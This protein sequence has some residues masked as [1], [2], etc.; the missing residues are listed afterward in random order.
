M[1]KFVFLASL[2]VMS[3][4]ILGMN[5]DRV[6]DRRYSSPDIWKSLRTPTQGRRYSAPDG[7][8]VLENDSVKDSDS[9][10]NGDAKIIK[11]HANGDT[12]LHLAVKK[13]QSRLGREINR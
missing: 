10:Y 7:L 13:K 6:R 12:S 11:S 8:R 5:I 1:K 4:R 9:R 3:F 2:A